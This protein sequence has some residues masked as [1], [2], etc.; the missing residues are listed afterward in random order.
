MQLLYLS[1][2]LLFWSF[3]LYVVGP[4]Q[5]VALAGRGMHSAAFDEL[6]VFYVRSGRDVFISCLKFYVTYLI[7]VTSRDEC[8]DALRVC[9]LRML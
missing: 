1:F 7:S 9:C 5:Q 8:R 4:L 3:T 6:Q 2:I